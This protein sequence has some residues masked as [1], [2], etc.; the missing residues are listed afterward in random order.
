LVALPFSSGPATAQTEN[1][2]RPAGA[3]LRKDAT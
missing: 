1:I 2:M 3:N